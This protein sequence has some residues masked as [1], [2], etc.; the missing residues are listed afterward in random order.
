[1]PISLRP[2][3][4]SGITINM[5]IFFIILCYFFSTPLLAF[6]F[7]AK[8]KHVFF[9]N[10]K[11]GEVLYE[12]DAHTPTENAS[13]TK[14]GTALYVYHLL[15]EEIYTKE[16]TARREAL[17]S[18]T[19]QAKRQ[20]NFRCPAWW[21]ETDSD[22]V[23]I[24]P[25]ETLTVY[26][27]LLAA[28]LESAN[29]AC[30]VLAQELGGTIPQFMEGM[31]E[32]LASIG[33]LNTHYMNPSGLS[34][35][36]HLTTAYDLAIMGR[37]LME[38]PELRKMVILPRYTCPET[39]YEYKRYF[40]NHN[41]LLRSGPYF[42]PY[43]LG[44][45]TGTTR[46]SG[47]NLV[48]AAQKDDRLLIGSFINYPYGERESLYKDVHKLFDTAFN[49]P[50]MERILLQAGESPL[51]KKVPG[52]RKPLQG[53]LAKPFLYSFYPSEESDVKMK[54]CW[55]PPSFPV[56]K[57][58]KIGKILLIHPSG[59]QLNEA[60]LYAARDVNP[61]LTHLIYLTIT[62]EYF[63]KILLLVI[64]SLFLSKTFSNLGRKRG[65]HNTRM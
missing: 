62:H 48:A 64:G 9:M 50:L 19:P 4:E 13:T 26:N 37:K 42:Y 6:D 43:A 45:K 17:A 5:G 24:K 59:V 57:G 65:Q 36:K 51:T 39:N 32:Y 21:I 55:Q 7:Q 58:E 49:E 38:I 56:K 53:Y 11:T 34:H 22:H 23:G 1:V 60:P 54:V 29:D 2:E 8:G 20:S 18:I 35:P 47:R 52:G 14:I 15:G 27:L 41:K 28:L 44:I 12:K 10:G 30:N 31:N 3:A 33:C 40:V 16:L 46:A 61:A 63:I 25:G